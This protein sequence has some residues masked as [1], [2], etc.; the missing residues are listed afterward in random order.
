MHDGHYGFN[1]KTIN[2]NYNLKFCLFKTLTL[3]RKSMM[4]KKALST[5]DFAVHQTV[6]L[7]NKL[8]D[9]TKG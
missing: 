3:N 1:W 6:N 4:D 7:L 8:K 2:L 5:K 9:T